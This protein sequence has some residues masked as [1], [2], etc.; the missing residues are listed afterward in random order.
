LLT[1]LQFLTQKGRDIF[2]LP[3]FFIM[4]KR[5]SVYTRWYR[6][7]HKFTGLAGLVFIAI[8]SVTGLLLIWKKNSGGM[9][10]AETQTGSSTNPESWLPVSRI[11]IAAIEYLKKQE[12]DADT[13]IDRL[14]I[15]PS[16]GVCKVTFTEHFSA[17]QVDMATGIPLLLEKRRADFIEQIH[18]G[19]ILDKYAG[20]GWFKLFYGSFVGLSLLFLTISGFFLWYHPK[21]IRRVK[22]LKP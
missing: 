8:I 19:S 5:I 22:R 1:Q 21:K 12:P 11:R 10:L 14:D 9:I 16:K 15:R 2:F 13:T 4:I 7:W 18:D 6:K 3:S 20:T 17:V